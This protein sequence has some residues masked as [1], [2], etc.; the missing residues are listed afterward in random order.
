MDVIRMAAA[1]KRRINELVKSE[2]IE[3]KSFPTPMPRIAVAGIPRS[4]TTMVFRAL[5]GLPPGSTTPKD[6]AGPHIKTHTFEPQSLCGEVDVAVFL[7]GDV[8]ESVVST[9]HKRY[10]ARHFRNCGAGHLSPET[11]DIYE[12]DHLNYERMFDA[13]MRPNGIPHACV[14]Y[15]DVHNLAPVIARLIGHE[16]SLPARVE[17]KT[18]SRAVTAQDRERIERAYSG[19]IE[20]VRLAPALSYYSG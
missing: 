4:G 2:L 14:R 18:T 5:A 15:E 10:D 1:I 7:F 12:G 6:Y 11:T 19:L 8:V 3:E 17:R 9:R 13:W 16:F 20:K